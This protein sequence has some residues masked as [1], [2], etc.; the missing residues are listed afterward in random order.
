[1]VDA[2]AVLVGLREPPHQREI[3]PFVQLER[4]HMTAQER[5]GV[6]QRLRCHA[7]RAD[8]AV[9]DQIVFEKSDD[10]EIGLEARPDF[11]EMGQLLARVVSGHRRIPDLPVDVRTPGFEALFEKERIRVLGR[12]AVPERDRVSQHEDAEC[13]RTLGEIVLTRIAQLEAIDVDRDAR[14]PS[15]VVRGEPLSAHRVGQ[16]EPRA[17]P[18]RLPGGPDPDLDGGRHDEG[19]HAYRGDRDDHQLAPGGPAHNQPRRQYAKMATY[20]CRM[21]RIWLSVAPARGWS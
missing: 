10:D 21:P 12:R 18:A 7:G 11:E 17:S 14:E 8:R 19:H 16:K 5:Q 13:I 1:M 15:V 20:S 2:A 6:C 3:R 9:V 4:I